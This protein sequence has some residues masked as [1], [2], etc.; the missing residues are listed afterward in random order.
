M[1]ARL[2]LRVQRRPAAGR[3]VIEACT[4]LP[5]YPFVYLRRGGVLVNK[6]P[7][8]DIL[9]LIQLSRQGLLKFGAICPSAGALCC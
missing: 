7:T 5:F 8:H 3:D 6:G 4:D 9:L 2:L 1:L